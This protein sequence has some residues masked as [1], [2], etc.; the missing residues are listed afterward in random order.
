M[1]GW[2]DDGDG[3]QERERAPPPA[4]REREREGGYCG[5]SSAPLPRFGLS[6]APRKE[7]G[8]EGRYTSHNNWMAHGVYYPPDQMRAEA[9][10]P[11]A[12]AMV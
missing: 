6:V 3:S 11:T 8:K 7:G 1:D 4:D 2:D 10:F 12:L 5:V 9:E